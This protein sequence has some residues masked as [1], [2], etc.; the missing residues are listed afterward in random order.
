[1]NQETSA[2]IIKLD[3]HAA[4]TAETKPEPLRLCVLSALEH[5]F[6]QL[7]GHE[8]SDLYKLVITEVEAPLFESVL[9]HAGGNQTR[10][11]N[12]LGISRSTLRKK[13]ALYGLDK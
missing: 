10:A 2:E 6:K 11:A 3:V 13:L 12:I 7:D 8:T 9:N 1:M 4:T 5:H